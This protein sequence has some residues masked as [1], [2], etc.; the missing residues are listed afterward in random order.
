M[1]DVDGRKGSFGKEER[2]CE[3]LHRE[4][5]GATRT[6]NSVIAG[7]CHDL[8]AEAGIDGLDLVAEQP[9]HALRVAQRQA[10]PDAHR[11][12]SVIYALAD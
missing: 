9:G 7:E 2:S 5:M 1:T 11:L 10:G 3:T 12:C 4:H 6:W 8:D